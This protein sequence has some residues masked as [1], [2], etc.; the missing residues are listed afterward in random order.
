LLVPS[1]TGASEDP[2]PA[3]PTISLRRRDHSDISVSGKCGGIPE[4]THLPGSLKQCLSSPTDAAA[5]EHIGFTTV[6]IAVW[7]TDNSRAP[8]SSQRH[9]IPHKHPAWL[10]GNDQA[11]W[12]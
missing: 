9:G 5:D 12:R 3:V 11:D 1:E 7:N 2:G 8:I 10:G 6:V 4:A